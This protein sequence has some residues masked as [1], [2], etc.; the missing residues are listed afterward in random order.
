MGQ[1]GPREFFGA[2][3]IAGGEGRAQ[4]A[5]GAAK[6]RSRKSSR[7]WPQNSSSL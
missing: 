4:F 3:K 7:S 6:A 5:H 1:C 2:R